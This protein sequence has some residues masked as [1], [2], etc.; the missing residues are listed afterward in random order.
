MANSKITITFHQDLDINNGIG[1]KIGTIEAPGLINQDF[2]WRNTRAGFGQVTKGTP[3]PTVGERS[4]INFLQAFNLD[5]NFTTTSGSYYN[6]SR[7]L[8]VVVI[9]TN[10][11]NQVF[12][13][14]YSGDN[15]AAIPIILNSYVTAVIV[16]NSAGVYEIVNQDFSESDSLPCQN[17][18]VEIETS[19]LTT[20]IES[21]VSIPSNS[22]NPF[23]FDLLRGQNHIFRLKNADG[24]EIN[25]FIRTP[26]ILDPN[27]FQIQVN[28]SPNGATVIVNSLNTSEGFQLLRLQYSLDNIDFQTSNVFSGL[29]EGNYSLF[30]KDQ[31]GCSIE[32]SFT[33]SEFGILTPYF[34]VSKTNSIRFAN[35]IDFGDAANYKND[36]NTLSCESNVILPYKECQLFQSSDVIKTQFKSNYSTHT[37]KVIKEDLTEFTVPSVKLSNNIGNKDLRDARKYN[38]GSNKTGIYF[39][40][41]N[42]YDFDSTIDTGEDYYLNGSLPTWVRIGGYIRV[43]M[44][45]FLIEDIIYDD[46]KNAE[47]IVIS[48]NYNAL[49]VAVIAG[50]IY[51]IF[52]YEV[53]EFEIDLVDYINQNIQVYLKAE[54]S[55]FV[56][57][58]Q[59]SEVIN[60][61]VKQEN[62]LSIE[63][64]NNENTDVFFATGIKYLIRIPF[65]KINGV[66]EDEYENIKTD[67]TTNLLN[68]D[69]FEV[70]EIIFEPV[71]KELWRKLKI[72]LSCK[73]VI[74]DGVRYVKNSTFETEGPLEDSNLYVLK[75]KMIKTGASFSSQSDGNID[76][77][78]GSEEVVGLIEIGTDAFVKYN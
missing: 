38:L 27:D 78:F 7:N 77:N 39:T 32:M 65:Y 2:I 17:V 44:E 52:D 71:T 33:V 29:V 37:V 30:I 48:N 54:N 47:V 46:N 26:N 62:T 11:E 3:N 1:F 75:A 69:I 5:W 41:G 40:T 57:I 12:T 55:N 60:V 45:W 73:N 43:D 4:A 23:S 18:K 76:F 49:D 28:S 15:L 42:I 31:I 67:S 56:T 59:L 19:Q 25:K 14:F 22:D 20:V 6:T 66:D 10:F 51:N 61:Q 64:W 24:I 58:E 34:Y 35:R 36:E 74:I 63:Y 72:A 70:D 21:P 13:D 16:N 9:E 50:F 8:N 68:S 53:Y